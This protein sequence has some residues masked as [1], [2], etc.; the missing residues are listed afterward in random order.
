[1]AEVDRTIPRAP[2]L[3]GA[4]GLLPFWGLAI[5]IGLAPL[6]GASA[7]SLATALA[8]YGA[9][10]VSFLGG[11]RWGLATRADQRA[12]AAQYGVAVL[13]S[14]LAWAALALPP[15]WSLAALG[16]VA[17]GLGPLDTG[18]VGTALAPAWY[19]RLRLILS[20]GA[21]AALLLGAALLGERA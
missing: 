6:G 4:A 9:I 7:P 2:L 1:M 8:T 12:V 21:G 16:V 20:C 19:G 10:I 15:A 3:L 5:G 11:I 13:P 18:L 14:L 17:L